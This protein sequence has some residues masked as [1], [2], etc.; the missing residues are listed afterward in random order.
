MERIG[1]ID[2]AISAITLHW[3]IFDSFFHPLQGVDSYFFPNELSD[4]RA[5]ISITFDSVYV[6][7]NE[8]YKKEE[9]P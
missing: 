7:I 6:G 1:A 5:S 9:K 4:F 8:I 2:E 3:N